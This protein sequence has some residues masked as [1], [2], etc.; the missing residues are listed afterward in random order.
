MGSMVRL[1]PYVLIAFIFAGCSKAKPQQAVALTDL[2]KADAFY[3]TRP[4]FQRPLATH[5]EPPKGLADLSAESC[6]QCHTEIYQEWKL[7]T[8]SH[9]WEDDAQFMAELHKS[10]TTNGDTGW[11]CVNCHTPI[12]NQ[13]PELVTG[14]NG[15][16][17]NEPVYVKNPAFDRKLQA[18]AITCATCHVRDGAILGPWGD[19]THAPHPVKREVNLLTEQTCARCH[20]AEAVFPEI[21]LGC[22]FDTGSQFASSPAAMRGETCQSCHMPQVERPAAIQPGLP[23]RKTR[24]HW[25]GGSLIPKKPE[26]AAELE[27][28]RKVYGSGLEI[29]VSPAGGEC[30]SAQ[31]CT[32]ATVSVANSHAGHH[33]PT[34]DPERHVEVHIV[35]RDGDTTIQEHDMF[36]GSKYKWWPKIEKTSDTRIPAGEYKTLKLELPPH[37]VTVEVTAW[38]YRMYADAF[39]LHEL[40]GK[41][42]R[43]REFHASTWRV[44][45]D[46]SELLKLNDDTRSVDNTHESGEQKPAEE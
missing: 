42:V 27:P 22:F 23:V 24:R 10:R 11:M 32:H 46:K 38:K 9:A 44:S 3:A 34:G 31:A 6:G 13:L 40:E 14:L 29:S 43:G 28:L 20:Q 16:K 30:K 15:G 35:V 45:P 36:F 33:V 17:L 5:Q 2:E 26:Y 37:P 4:T 25:F 41:Y 7:S 19:Q 1:S 8:H 21:N 18:E 39:K 12:S